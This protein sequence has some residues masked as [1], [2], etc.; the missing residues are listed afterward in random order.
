[1][2][3]LARRRAARRTGSRSSSR[4]AHADVADRHAQLA[5]HGHR[6]PALRG[7]VELG[8]DEAG[9][10]R[11]LGELAALGEAV[12]A[13]GGIQHEQR[14]VRRARAPRA[15]P[16]APSSASSA[17]RL[18]LVCSRPAVS[19]STASW[20]RARAMR[21]ASVSTARGIG[22]LRAAVESR[23]ARSAQIS[24]CS[25]AAA[26]KVSAAHS[27]VV[28]PSR[29]PGRGELADG[30][31]LPR[32]VHAHHEDDPGPAE[33]GGRPRGRS[34]ALRTSLAQHRPHRPSPPV[35]IC[36]A[37]RPQHLHGLVHRG[38]PEVGGDQRLLD[39]LEGRRVRAGAGRAPGPRPRRSA[40]RGCAP[41]RRGTGRGTSSPSQ[42]L[43]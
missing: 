22:A 38:Q 43:R 11:R 6:H 42:L 39:R 12:A 37:L 32:A 20:P 30:R 9:D 41:A 3:A 2:S 7:P 15:P 31:G 5:H 8:E 33:N 28:R 14:L 26:R 23:A 13:H 19:T 1:M 17:I 40:P 35:A 25:A 34:R 27:S 10:A 24:S 21:R 29:L 18:P 36:A 16:R 4:L